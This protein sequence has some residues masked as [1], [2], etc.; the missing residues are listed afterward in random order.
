MEFTYASIPCHKL[1]R[2]MPK[3][4]ISHYIITLHSVFGQT[5]EVGY[6]L[7]LLLLFTLGIKKHQASKETPYT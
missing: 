2:L 4:I 3:V 1:K 6:S 5:I 7:S